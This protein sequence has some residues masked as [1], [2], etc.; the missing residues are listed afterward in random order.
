M[1]AKSCSSSG[2]HNVTNS[3]PRPLNLMTKEETIR[4]APWIAPEVVVFMQNGG[5]IY[6]TVSS[7]ACRSALSESTF[8]NLPPFASDCSPTPSADSYSFARLLQ[9]L[10]D[11]SCASRFDPEKMRKTDANT[12]VDEMFHSRSLLLRDMRP[13]V[14]AALKRDPFKRAPLEKLHSLIVHMFWDFYD[15]QSSMCPQR[16]PSLRQWYESFAHLTL[17][18][19]QTASGLENSAISQETFS[20]SASQAQKFMLRL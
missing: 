15:I 18:H 11:P 14:K 5:A 20:E 19:H 17:H 12:E 13:A 8:E 16:P 4:L 7:P 9:E 1:N 6:N 2:D 10:F 3:P